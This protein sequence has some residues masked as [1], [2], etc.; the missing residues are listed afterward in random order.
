V[1]RFS[2]RV[3][4]L[5]GILVFAVLMYF[6][7]RSRVRI[8]GLTKFKQSLYWSEIGKNCFACQP[9]FILGYSFV[10]LFN[11]VVS[12]GFHNLIEQYTFFLFYP[13]NIFFNFG[14]MLFLQQIIIYGGGFFVVPVISAFLAYEK[15]VK[16]LNEERMPNRIWFHLV[17]ILAISPVITYLIWIVNP[18][19][20]SPGVQVAFGTFGFL[21]SMLFFSLLIAGAIAVELSYHK[22]TKKT[23]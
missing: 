6:L 17:G 20:F 15:L 1:T 4:A 10:G 3:E 18:G 8:S 11:I 2:R 16:P 9:L 22:L 13:F 12:M 5:L 21:F 23:Q 7:Y 19:L 14:L